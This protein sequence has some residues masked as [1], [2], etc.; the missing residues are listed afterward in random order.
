MEV[1]FKEGD[2][3]VI[4]FHMEDLN[5]ILPKLGFGIDKDGF[6]IDR[7]GARIKSSLDSTQYIKLEDI[8]V[9]ASGSE[10]KLIT[11]DEEYNLYLFEK[12]N[13]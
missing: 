10:A 7:T 6:V 11:S 4:P 2:T 8:L 3:V 12:T 9:I 1:K 13:S 5:D